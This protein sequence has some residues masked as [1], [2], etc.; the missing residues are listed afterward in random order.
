MRLLKTLR[1]LKPRVV[2]THQLDDPHPDHDHVAR[3]VRESC[4]LS[5]MK[6]YDPDTGEDKD[7]GSDGCSQRV[8][9]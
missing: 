4:R 6:N 3:I 7:S 2:L 8:F 9:G 5:S 1:R